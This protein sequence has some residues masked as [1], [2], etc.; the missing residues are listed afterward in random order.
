MITHMNV[1]TLLADLL[2]HIHQKEK[3]HLKS[4]QQLQVLYKA[5][6]YKCLKN[7]HSCILYKQTA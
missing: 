4:H 1:S 6:L 5:G 2:I 3:S 7:L